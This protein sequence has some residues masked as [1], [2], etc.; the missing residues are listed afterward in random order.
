MGTRPDIYDPRFCEMQDKTIEEVVDRVQRLV[1]EYH[2]NNVALSDLKGQLNVITTRVPPDLPVQ[3]T[4]LQVKHDNLHTDFLA[5]QGR[6][7][8]VLWL[9][10][11]AAAA[12]VAGFALRGGFNR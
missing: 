10:I 9:F 1:D 4:A 7:Y 5:L 8:A 3:L 2:E 12:S 6:I 11:A